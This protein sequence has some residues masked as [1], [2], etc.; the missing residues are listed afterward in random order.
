MEKLIYMK[1]LKEDIRAVQYRA[2]NPP[3]F[4][5]RNQVWDQLGIQV[6]EQ[7]WSRCRN[8]VISQIWSGP[9]EKLIKECKKVKI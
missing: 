6:G 8:H 1:L 2:V 9:W 4:K 5:I 3:W 7:I